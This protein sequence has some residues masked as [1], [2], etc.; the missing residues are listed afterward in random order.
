MDIHS[1][2]S[3]FCEKEITSFLVFYKI[4]ISR[5]GGYIKSALIQSINAMKLKRRNAKKEEKHVKKF[6]KVLS[7][8]L[9]MAMIL[10]LFP[11]PEVYAEEKICEFTGG[12]DHVYQRNCNNT[13]GEYQRESSA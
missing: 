1:F 7:L 11:T 5:K 13:T 2:I 4:Q 6:K 10:P 9:A 12:N 8:V 3:I